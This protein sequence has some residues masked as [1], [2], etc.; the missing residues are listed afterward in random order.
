MDQQ[1]RARVA[2]FLRTSSTG[3]ASVSTNSD[4]AQSETRESL[5]SLT[6]SENSL[7]FYINSDFRS[8]FLSVLNVAKRQSQG[9]GFQVI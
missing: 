2:E 5:L 6:D 9:H 8:Y 1:I 3:I 4:A 7:T